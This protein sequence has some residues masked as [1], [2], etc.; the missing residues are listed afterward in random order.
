MN[1]HSRL[2]L[3]G[4]LRSYF[5]RSW[6][7]VQLGTKF[8]LMRWN[9]PAGLFRHLFLESGTKW[10]LNHTFSRWWWGFW[11]GGRVGLEYILLRSAF[12]AVGDE[13]AADRV[14]RALRTQTKVGVPSQLRLLPAS[15]RCRW[16][17]TQREMYTPCRWSLGNVKFQL[18]LAQ[19]LCRQH[20]SSHLH[21]KPRGSVEQLWVTRRR[22]LEVR[23]RGETGRADVTWSGCSVSSRSSCVPGVFF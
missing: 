2:V 3:A 12:T 14:T 7:D 20:P 8:S 17:L 16:S 19:N 21:R 5:K 4:V 9:C 1:Q 6:A 13:A 23:G 15:P 10:C 11:G 18:R 22:P